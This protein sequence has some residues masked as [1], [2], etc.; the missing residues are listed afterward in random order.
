[1]AALGDTVDEF[2]VGDRVAVEAH[3]GCLRCK[4]GNEAMNK[5]V[6]LIATFD[7][8][9]QEALYLKQCIEAMGVRVLVMDAG[10]LGS[11]QTGE[12]I[13]REEVARRGGMA[14]EDAV[15][16]KDK[17]LCTEVM[18]KGCELITRELYDEGRI[19]GVV[20]IG[21]AQG[22]E[23][24]CTA[25]RALPTGV[26]RL[27]ASTVANGPHQFGFYM[28]TKD[29]TIMHTVSDMQGLNFL[30][31]RILENSAG[32][33]CGMVKSLRAE[34][35]TPHGIPVAMSMLGTTTP[36]ALRA[37][38]ILESHGFE[39]VA[40]H[41]NGTGG[42]AMEDMI[43]EGP[44]HGVLDLNLHEIGDRYV[45]GLHGAIRDDRLTA[46]G[47]MG[48]PQVVAPGS[49]NYTVQ[50]GPE[51]LS[52]DMN[53]RKRFNYNPHLTLV[54]L[55][56]QELEEVGKE[57]ARK[58]NRAKGPVKVFIPLKGFSFPDREGLPH[59]EPEGNQVFIDTLKRHL[60]PGIPLVEINEHI[61]DP[62]FIDPVVDEFMA[63]MKKS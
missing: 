17:S 4:R 20:G 60:S 41:Q 16:T 42:I 2:K 51:T 13:L 18:C 35:M 37:K 31:R 28:G 33:I 61:N 43:R 53:R 29:L 24:A 8:K 3:L 6:L 34:A 62:G 21:G 46:A 50:G 15:A 57:I 54:R 56:P 10:I 27:M 1:V 23:I 58:L 63:L 5:T 44:F 22:T 32:A 25:M 48:L 52:E 14:L 12:C 45:K 38:A 7:T 26:P 39:V 59:W 30:T 11:P 36:G 55:L 9:A 40:F 19:Q 47:D 49:G